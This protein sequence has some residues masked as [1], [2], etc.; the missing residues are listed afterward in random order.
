MLI[1]LAVCVNTVHDECDRQTDGR[2]EELQHYC[3]LKW[4]LRRTVQRRSAKHDQTASQSL[5]FPT[6]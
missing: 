3:A 5:S 2:T 4:H 6:F 1:D